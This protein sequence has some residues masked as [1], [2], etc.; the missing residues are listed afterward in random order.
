MPRAETTS[1]GLGDGAAAYCTHPQQPN[2]KFQGRLQ[3]ARGEKPLG[4][5]QTFQ[6]GF[7]Q[8]MPRR[9]KANSPAF[10]KQKHHED[11]VAKS[12]CSAPSF[13]PKSRQY[14]FFQNSKRTTD[15]HRYQKI[16]LPLHLLYCPEC[17]DTGKESFPLHILHFLSLCMGPLTLLNMQVNQDAKLQPGTLNEHYWVMFL[18][19][20][21]FSWV[22]RIYSHASFFLKYALVTA[23]TRLCFRRE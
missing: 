19:D 22:T 6:C 20:L 18:S 9:R 7:A 17:K 5:L 10:S 4:T 16:P 11:H 13:P 1:P 8:R 21:S 14:I 3:I 2:S 15:N 23:F 12:R